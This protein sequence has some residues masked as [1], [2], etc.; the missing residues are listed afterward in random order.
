MSY[1]TDTLARRRGARISLINPRSRCPPW[2][3]WMVV[4]QHLKPS[5]RDCTVL[6]ASGWSRSLVAGCCGFSSALRSVGGGTPARTQGEQTSNQTQQ[7][8]VQYTNGPI[9]INCVD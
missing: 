8:P 5:K 3:F 6:F 2:A 4:Q 9:L 7:L 1:S